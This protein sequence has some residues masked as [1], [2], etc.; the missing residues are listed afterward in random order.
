MYNVKGQSGFMI[1]M[2]CYRTNFLRIYIYV[3]IYVHT[4]RDILHVDSLVIAT[5]QLFQIYKEYC[6]NLSCK[7][8]M[9]VG[10]CHF[11][12]ISGVVKHAR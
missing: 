2:L 4:S 11:A 8:F 5:L 1:A 3:Y 7:R 10:M 12:F 9:P 6:M